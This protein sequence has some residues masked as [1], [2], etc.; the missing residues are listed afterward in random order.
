[1]FKYAIGPCSH[2][3]E[4]DCWS[5]LRSCSFCRR[6]AEKSHHEVRKGD[7]SRDRQKEENCSAFSLKI[8]SCWS[9]LPLHLRNKISARSPH[10]SH[11]MRKPSSNCN[12]RLRHQKVIK[13][14]S[15]AGY[16]QVSIIFLI[17]HQVFL[18]Q[19]FSMSDT[20]KLQ[21]MIHRP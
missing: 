5:P 16:Q 1:M 4:G 6:K 2:S 20:P 15:A 8:D 19:N 11:P 12:Q 14:P 7:G 10:T 9:L 17:P 13:Q 3:M 21:K 18:F